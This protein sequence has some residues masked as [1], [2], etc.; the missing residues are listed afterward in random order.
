MTP[1]EIEL[2]TMEVFI[3]QSNDGLGD[4]P[5]YSWSLLQ[6]ETAKKIEHSAHGGSV[7]L[8]KRMFWVQHSIAKWVKVGPMLRRLDLYDGSTSSPALRRRGA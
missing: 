5:L 1:F 8:E 6:P 7:S 3:H 4:E 2:S